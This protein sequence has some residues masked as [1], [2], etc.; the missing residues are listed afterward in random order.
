MSGPEAL[1]HGVEHRGAGLLQ[2]TGDGVGVDDHR[3]SLGEQGGH[4]GLAGPDPAGETDE[5]HGGRG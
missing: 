3:P 5:E 1:D 2:L 4:G